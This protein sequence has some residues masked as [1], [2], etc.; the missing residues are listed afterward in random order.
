MSKNQVPSNA[1]IKTVKLSELRVSTGAQREFKPS[2]GDKLAENFDIDK[3]GTF[4]TSHRDGLYWILDGQHRFYALKMWAKREFGAEWGDWTIPVWAHE[5]LDETREAELFLAFNDRKPVNAFDKFKVGVTAQLPVPTDIDRIVR[6]LDLRVSNTG[7]SGSVAAVSTMEKLYS[8]GG[9][10]L[11]SKALQ[12]LRDAW[13][14]TDFDSNCL[15]GVGLFI[16]RYEGRYDPSR[17][18]KKL[19]ALTNASKALRHGAY[20][21]REKS[22]VSYPIAHAAAVTDV[23]NKGL[24]GKQSL[25]S[26]WKN[27]EE[28]VR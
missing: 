21:V 18:V 3:V 23:Y 8:T 14:S 26:W 27:D 5:G 22:G 20:M 19:A 4:T 15:H 17:L 25:G 16:N 28:A 12:T 2:W 6:A 10:A 7:Q 9:A 1:R 24:R 13:D 11:L